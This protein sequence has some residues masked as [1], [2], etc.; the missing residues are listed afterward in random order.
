M[1]GCQAILSQGDELFLMLIWLQLNLKEQDIANRFEVSISSVS[2][3][4]TTW[5]YE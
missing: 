2:R 5:I 4:F 3:V 1:V